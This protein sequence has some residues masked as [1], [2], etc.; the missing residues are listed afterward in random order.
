MLP[1]PINHGARP[2]FLRAL[3]DHIL[4]W[5][6]D[7]KRAVDEV[8]RQ[9]FNLTFDQ[10]LVRNPRFIAE[11]T[12]RYVPPPSILVP[13]IEHVYKMFK[14]AI[15]AKTRVPLFTEAFSAKANAVLELA[16]QGYLSDVVDI[17]MYERAGVDKYGLQTWKCVRG[18]NK[19]E[20]GPHGDIYRKFGALHGNYTQDSVAI[21]TTDISHKAG[22]R[23]TTNCLTDHRTWYNLQVSG[24][25]PNL[26]RLHLTSPIRHMQFIY[27]VSTGSIIT[28][29]DY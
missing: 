24:N 3:R 7:A 14:D 15:D 26:L 2:A 27:S 10:M 23:L 4:R 20:G 16:R 29:L 6:P 28:I 5:D 19:V 8:C 17:P 22:P 12:P 21:I 9:S 18:T 13:A 25:I 11:R 1:I